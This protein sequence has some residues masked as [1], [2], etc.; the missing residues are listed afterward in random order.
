MEQEAEVNMTFDVGVHASRGE[1][2]VSI[3]HGVQ[4]QGGVGTAST[5]VMNIPPLYVRMYVCNYLR[6]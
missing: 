4:V 1:Y 5:T 6:T 3:G 2:A